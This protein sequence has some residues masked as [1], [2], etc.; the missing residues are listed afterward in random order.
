M[1]LV[2]LTIGAGLLW[3]FQGEGHSTLIENPLADFAIEDTSSVDR[4]VIVDTQGKVVDLRRNDESRYW[5]LN[6]KYLARKDATD[7]LLKTF[8]RIRVKSPVPKAAKENV[9]KRMQTG[10]KVSIYN[11]GEKPAK[12]YIVGSATQ[13]HTGTYMILEKDGERSTEPF[14]THME[15]FT[16]FLSTRFFTDELDWR[17][18]GVFD[19]PNLDIKKLEV[20]HHEN[21]PMSF[22][23]LV[24]ED[25][26][27]DLHSRLLDKDLAYFD[28]LKLRNYLLQYK[29]IHLETYNSHLTPQGEDSL[30]NAN[31]V[32]TLRVTDNMDKVKR[33]DLYRKKPLVGVYDENDQ[34]Y[35]EDISRMYGVVDGNEVVLIQR[36]LFDPLFAGLQDFAVR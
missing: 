32:Y 14:I 35:S 10:K 15:G 9:I 23:V 31:P 7:L 18:T 17:Y 27:L 20:I 1:I 29:K 13:D 19:Y 4:I 5:S 16:G 33:I 3:K 34:P 25:N 26:S 30:L 21:E 8:K 28:T 22:D 24:N 36:Q 2:V 12:V 6:N 11:G